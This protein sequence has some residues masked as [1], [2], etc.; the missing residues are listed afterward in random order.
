MGTFRNLC[1]HLSA[2]WNDRHNN[3]LFDNSIV[4]ELWNYRDDK[5][6]VHEVP[7]LDYLMSSVRLYLRMKFAGD[8]T[9]IMAKD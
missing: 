5:N 2:I 6:V 9:G 8:D 1:F 3:Q 4:P 7:T